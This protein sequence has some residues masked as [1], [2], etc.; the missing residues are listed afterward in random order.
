MYVKTKVLV[1]MLSACIPFLEQLLL[2][3]SVFSAF[4]VRPDDQFLRSLVGTLCL[5]EDIVITYFL[6]LVSQKD[7]YTL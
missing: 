3:V 5:L 1:V 2:C 4:N 6:T 7:V